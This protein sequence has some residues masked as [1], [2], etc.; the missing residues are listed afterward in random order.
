MKNRI[1]EIEGRGCAAP[2]CS[3]GLTDVET[4]LRKMVLHLRVPAPDAAK[5]IE[6]A[7]DIVAMCGKSEAEVIR[8]KNAIR[9][10]ATDFER[11]KWGWDGDCGSK[12]LVDHL[13]FEISSANVEAW[14]PDPGARPQWEVK[15]SNQ[16]C[17]STRSGIGLVH[18]RFVLPACHVRDRS[19]VSSSAAVAPFRNSS[20]G[21]QRQRNAMRLLPR[22]DISTPLWLNPVA[23]L[24]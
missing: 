3:P 21:T 2:P 15:D 17:Q 4:E 22:F 12:E 6:L 5:V 10:F 20:S 23:N 18:R 1:D 16:G 14:Q 24:L 9:S 8:L 13:F 11:I 19:I 7:A